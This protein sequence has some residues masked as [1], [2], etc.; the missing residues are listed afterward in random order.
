MNVCI[1]GG[2][3]IDVDDHEWAEIAS[4]RQARSVGGGFHEDHRLT[5]AERADG[6]TIVYAVS[7]SPDEEP[8]TFGEVVVAGSELTPAIRRVAEIAG[9]L[10][11][12]ADH[13]ISQLKNRESE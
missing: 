9:L 5:V 3:T 12:F 13:C 8:R 11:H 7:Q 6:T 10:G 2:E 1:A 4:C